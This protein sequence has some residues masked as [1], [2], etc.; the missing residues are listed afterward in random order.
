MPPRF[1]P[2]MKVKRF[3]RLRRCLLGGETRLIVASCLSALFRL[4]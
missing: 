2:Q 1:L 3:D 4:L